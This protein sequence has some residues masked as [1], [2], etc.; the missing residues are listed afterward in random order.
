MRFDLVA[1]IA[2][3]A[4]PWRV[5]LGLL[6][7]WGAVL[8][9][10]NW[11]LRS[12]PF[13]FMLIF[14]VSAIRGTLGT[15]GK[16]GKN[17]E[18]VSADTTGLRINDQLLM[19]RA[20]IVNAYCI[21]VRDGEGYAVHVEGRF[22]R[23]ACTVFVSSEEEG[24]KLLEAFQVDATQST[25][26][27]RA[28]PPWAKH[29]RWLA[30]LLTAS[31]WVLINVIRLVPAWGIAALVALYGVVLLPTFLPQRVEVG[32][33]GLLLKW[34]GNSHFVAFSKIESAT[35]TKLGVHLLLR[36][37]RHLEIRLTQKDGS[38]TAQIDALL[39][40]IK[41]GIDAQ[42]GLSRADEEAALARSNRDLETWIRAMR[43]L[44]SGEASG[45]RVAAIPRERLWE[46]VESPVADPSAREGAAFALSAIV[47]EDTRSRL[48][49]LAKKT[50][51]PGL[52][53]ALDWAILGDEQSARYRIA[54]EAEAS[55]SE[56]ESESESESE[57]AAMRARR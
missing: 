28:L 52:R 24:R 34:L 11:H 21:P 6:L 26:H 2:K 47:D 7:V 22:L 56:G 29:L 33:D 53:A 57:S 13:V 43:A 46:I 31:P 54:L 37:D 25:A 45:Y 44:G 20:A 10:S 40:R 12:L 23:Q 17:L 48:S 19:D 36:G 39:A 4:F 5:G 1:P 15:S 8:Y 55:E 38:A 9:A 27:F 30:I 50:A 41:A 14:L 42:S 35:A 49:A 18:K 51:Q 16:R 32:H 3:R